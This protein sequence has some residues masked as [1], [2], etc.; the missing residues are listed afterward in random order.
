MVKI[1]VP[2]DGYN[3]PLPDAVATFDPYT[4]NKK[5]KVVEDALFILRNNVKGMVSCNERFEKLPNGR[6]FD[7]ILA[8]DTIHISYDPSH[9]WCANTCG[10]DI[11]INEYT[12]SRGRW[13]VAATLVHKFAHI[14]GA[15][16]TD[17]RAEATLPPCG[18]GGKGLYDP[19]IRT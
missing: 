12:I 13:L 4:D 9:K 14:N 11:T 16:A 15:P 3:A 10:N 2:G 6:T 7:D 19:T 8:D 17:H 1:H 18:M 5:K